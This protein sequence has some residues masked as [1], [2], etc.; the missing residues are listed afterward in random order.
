MREA[1]GGQLS[2]LC[3]RRCQS[4]TLLLL[5]FLFLIAGCKGGGGNSGA[6]NP[7]SNSPT[8]SPWA[9]GFVSGSSG[10]ATNSLVVNANLILSSGQ[11]QTTGI[12]IGRACIRP[13]FSSESITGSVSG[14][15]VSLTLSFG[16]VTILLTANPFRRRKEHERDVHDEWR[17]RQRYG[18]LDSYKSSVSGR[19]LHR[20]L[21]GYESKCGREREH[22]GKPN[23]R[24]RR[25]RHWNLFNRLGLLPRRLE[26]DGDTN[27]F[28]VRGHGNR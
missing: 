20:I 10:S 27:G 11:L 2:G 26:C 3:S 9:F 19:N 7:T 25:Q 8:A 4:R 28:P 14:N 15:S 5:A 17:L 13:R 16:G 1:S 6:A 21:S 12:L 18:S 23:E 24:Q 22:Y